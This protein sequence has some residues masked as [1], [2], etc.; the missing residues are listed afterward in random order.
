M[1]SYFIYFYLFCCESLEFTINVVL[2]SLTVS[3]FLNCIS[4]LKN[5]VIHA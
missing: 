4:F 1:N 2:K 3:H 5:Y